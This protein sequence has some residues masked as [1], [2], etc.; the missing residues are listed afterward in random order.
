[1]RRKQVCK[2]YRGVRAGEGGGGIAVDFVGGLGGRVW[3][4]KT[5]CGLFEH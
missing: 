1:M 5:L 4:L 3:L 2:F